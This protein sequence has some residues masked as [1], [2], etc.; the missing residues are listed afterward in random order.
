M[1]PAIKVG[2]VWRRGAAHL[3]SSV[4]V[5][6]IRNGY[7]FYKIQGSDLSVSP[8]SVESFLSLFTLVSEPAKDTD[9]QTGY[10]VGDKLRVVDIWGDEDRA[11]YP[12]E[13]KRG[14]IFTVTHINPLTSGMYDLSCGLW[15]LEKASGTTGPEPAGKRLVNGQRWLNAEG[16][17]IVT[18]EVGPDEV[19]YYFPGSQGVLRMPREQFLRD[20]TAPPSE[21]L[22]LEFEVTES[23][24]MKHTGD[25][26]LSG[27]V[28]TL[29][30]TA[31]HKHMALGR[32]KYPFGNWTLGLSYSNVL[33]GVR[34]HS[35][36]LRRL[37]DLDPET[38]SH[39]LL[40]VA[41]N[42]M[43]GYVL[44]QT[45]KLIDDRKEKFVDAHLEKK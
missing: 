29:F 27:E 43:M 34:R 6:D 1:K 42:A 21:P 15:E 45:G 13:I 12:K 36:A 2:Q 39:H 33:E 24:G 28:P 4:R 38:G 32:K 17:E 44:L 9:R 35:D 19:S 5:V 16:V 25:K 3:E 7:V 37:E 18:L 11:S 40:A 8:Y 20:V 31:L 23:G 41:A 22:D 14:H 10:K 26:P 30:I